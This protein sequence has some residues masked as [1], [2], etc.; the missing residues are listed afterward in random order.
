MRWLLIF[1]SI[2]CLHQNRHHIESLL[3]EGCR[4]GEKSTLTECTPLRSDSLAQFAV[5]YCW[6]ERPYSA[7]KASPMAALFVGSRS[8]LFRKVHIAGLTFRIRR[9]VRTVEAQNVFIRLAN[10]KSPQFFQHCLDGLASRYRDGLQV[11]AADLTLPRAMPV[12]KQLQL[13]SDIGIWSCIESSKIFPST[14]LH[15]LRCSRAGP[16]RRSV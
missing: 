4:H 8:G 9:Q 2:Q 1:E 11:M 3:F 12:V 7:E 15:Q 14:Q 6:S 16:C 10:L 13:S 5:D